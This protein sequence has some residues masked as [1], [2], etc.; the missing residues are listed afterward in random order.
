MHLLRQV[1]GH[2]SM[3]VPSSLARA[4]ACRTRGETPGDREADRRVRGGAGGQAS[5]GRSRAGHRRRRSDPGRHGPVEVGRERRPHHPRQPR[6]VPR[7]ARSRLLKGEIGRFRRQNAWRPKKT[8]QE[9]P[10]E[11]RKGASGYSGTPARKPPLKS[12]P[13]AAEHREA[14]PTPGGASHSTPGRRQCFGNQA[15]SCCG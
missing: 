10:G 14:L 1:L 15:P 2:Q 3:P 12:P 5:G 11:Q 9:S 8:A 4:Q 7:A 13:V 6:E